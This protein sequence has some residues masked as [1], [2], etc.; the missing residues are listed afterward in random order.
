L[1]LVPKYESHDLKHVLLD[2]KMTPEDEIRMQAFMLGNGNITLPCIVILVFG[3]I[4]IPDR[5][6]LLI[7]DF[8]RG[9]QVRPISAWTIEEYADKSTEEL[10]EYVFNFQRDKKE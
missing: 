2:F 1:G 4:F 9:S 8:K 5:W 6:R 3:A 7:N 10:R